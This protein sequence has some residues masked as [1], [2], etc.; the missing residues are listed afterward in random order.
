M[1][2]GLLIILVLAGA[3]A[4]LCVCGYINIPKSLSPPVKEEKKTVTPVVEE[5]TEDNFMLA[6]GEM[7]DELR[8][9][10]ER[11]FVNPEESQPTEGVV[12]FS[13]EMG[14]AL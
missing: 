5:K 11:D 4:L 2:K 14:S 8:E 3:V 6:D 1:N 12:G 7:V 9:Y 10:E 13:Q